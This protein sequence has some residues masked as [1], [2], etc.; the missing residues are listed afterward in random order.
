MAVTHYLETKGV[1]IP[2]SVL[3]I[4]IDTYVMALA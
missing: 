1:S 4:L 2:D 3:Y